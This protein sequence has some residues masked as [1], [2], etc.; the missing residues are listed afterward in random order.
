MRLSAQTQTN[1]TE[2][3][4][5]AKKYILPTTAFPSP[6]THRRCDI[7]LSWNIMSSANAGYGNYYF[8]HRN[9][10]ALQLEK[11]NIQ[12]IGVIGVNMLDGWRVIIVG[13]ST[14]CTFYEW[15]LHAN[16]GY[17]R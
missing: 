15:A 3:F 11:T 14:L 12:N 6:K 2:L 7:G 9:I 4:P 17:E 16:V 5:G 8:S 13:P 10:P 1:M